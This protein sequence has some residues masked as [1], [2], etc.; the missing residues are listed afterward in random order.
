MAYLGN[1]EYKAD[2]KG[3][4][5]SVKCPLV[6]DWISPTDCMEN[7]SVGDQFIPTQF[8]KNPDWKELCA[9]CPLR[10]Y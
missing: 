8:K 10:D 7:Q 6:D 9:G 2:G 1:V 4:A 5:A 3:V